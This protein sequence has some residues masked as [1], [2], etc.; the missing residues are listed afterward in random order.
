MSFNYILVVLFDRQV[1][2]VLKF[3]TFIAQRNVI[4]EIRFVPGF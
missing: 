3:Y 1:L 4:F 2:V